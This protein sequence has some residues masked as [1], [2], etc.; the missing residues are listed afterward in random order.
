[1]YTEKLAKTG[2][3]HGM[4]VE[5]NGEEE[6][7]DRQ[8]REA[9]KAEQEKYFANKMLAKKKQDV[10]YG[11]SYER[12]ILLDS[13]RYNMGQDVDFLEGCRRKAA[14]SEGKTRRDYQ[15]TKT[16]EDTEQIKRKSSLNPDYLTA[17]NMSEFLAVNNAELN[18]S[19]KPSEEK[20]A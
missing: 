14:A 20:T 13:E 9:E 10:R 3:M 2:Q 6:D 11:P 7:Q 17:Y 5:D 1:M 12:I 18:V 4:G 16:V 19:A 8:Q 15:M